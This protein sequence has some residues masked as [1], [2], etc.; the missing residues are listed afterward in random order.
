MGKNNTDG[1]DNFVLLNEYVTSV[2]RSSE[3]S[4]NKVIWEVIV[5]VYDDSFSLPTT[6]Q[7]KKPLAVNLFAGKNLGFMLAYCDNDGSKE[8]EHFIGSTYK[9]CKR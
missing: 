3:K 7:I 1:S 8:R 6:K 9:G 5:R 2:W 4:A